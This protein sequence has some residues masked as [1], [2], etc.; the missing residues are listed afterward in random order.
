MLILIVLMSHTLLH[1]PL[2]QK[3]A[4]NA[5]LFFPLPCGYM[6]ERPAVESHLLHL[7]P[8]DIWQISIRPSGVFI[9]NMKGGGKIALGTRHSA[10]NVLLC[11]LS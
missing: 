8:L 3:T 11:V 4:P 9:V 7:V 10:L 6:V 5:P 1:D 2:G